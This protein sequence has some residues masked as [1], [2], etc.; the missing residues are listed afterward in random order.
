MPKL[1]ESLNVFGKPSRAM[2]ET[3]SFVSAGLVEFSSLDDMRRYVKRLLEYY[4]K[5]SDNFGDAAA[6]LMREAEAVDSDRGKIKPFPEIWKKKGSVLVD[7][8]Y[9]VRGKIQVMLEIVDECKFKI[10]KTTEALKSLED[11]DVPKWASVTLHIG[12]GVPEKVIV[13]RGESVE[14]PV[15]EPAPA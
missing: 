13:E 9:P 10:A 6:I 1:D 12:G 2:P 5:E 3:D 11:L 7:T 8:D 4:E 15:G 14:T